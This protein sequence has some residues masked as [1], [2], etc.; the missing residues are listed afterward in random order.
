MNRSTAL[1][2]VGGLDGKRRV[3][4]A[5]EPDLTPDQLVPRAEARRSMLLDRQMDCESAG[6]LPAETNRAFDA[7]GFYR[8]IQPRYFGGYEFDLPTFM[9]VIMAVSR[10]CTESGWAL[11]L[12]AGHPNLVA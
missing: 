4:P 5:P 11:A 8:T 2:P 1:A 6:C 12:I 7:A 10:G 9:R 3:I